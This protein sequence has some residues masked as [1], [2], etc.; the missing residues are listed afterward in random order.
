MSDYIELTVTLKGEETTHRK[1]HQLYEPLTLSTTDL[2]VQELV[3][4]SLKEV[5]FRPED[6]VLTARMVC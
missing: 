4:E 3:Q 5:K 1:K 6:V 2:K